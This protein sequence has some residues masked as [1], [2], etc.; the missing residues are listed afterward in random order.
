MTVLD[1]ESPFLARVGY[2]SM[3]GL[4]LLSSTYLPATVRRVTLDHPPPL[5]RPGIGAEPP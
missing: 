5:S 2:Q 4:G 3:N 1:R